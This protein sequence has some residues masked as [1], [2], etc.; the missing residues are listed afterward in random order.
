MIVNNVIVN[1]DS[2][3]AFEWLLYPIALYI[4]WQFIYLFITEIILAKE[5]EDDPDIV[6]SFRY[7]TTN[8]KNPVGLLIETMKKDKKLNLDATKT[9]M[10]F[11]LSQFLY[12]FLSIL[13]AKLFYEYY[14]ASLFFLS[15]MF[16]WGCWNGASYYLEVFSEHYNLQFINIG[17]K[18][19]QLSKREETSEDSGSEKEVIHNEEKENDHMSNALEEDLTT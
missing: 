16:I 10:V 11:I 2:L 19:I 18:C 12:T 14:E 15:L 1:E 17:E 7:M 6:T 9:K 3:N 8:K 13:P 5:L 4:A